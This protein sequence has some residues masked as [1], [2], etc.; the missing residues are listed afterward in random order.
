MN[1]E[2][3]GKSRHS[4]PSEKWMRMAKIYRRF[5]VDFPFAD[6]SEQ[7][8]TDMFLYESAGVPLPTNSVVNGYALGKKWMDVTVSMW[9]ED[10]PKG[11]LRAEELLDDGYP[12]WFLER[13]GIQTKRGLHNSNRIKR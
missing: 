8:A 9:K 12:E 1:S 2:Y 7:A 11:L 4:G 5:A 10:I 6:F 13:V 3:K